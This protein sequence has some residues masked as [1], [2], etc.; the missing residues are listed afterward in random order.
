M[1]VCGTGVQCASSPE[2]LLA[3]RVPELQLH[4]HPRLH[5][6]K[7]HVEVHPHRLVGG[8]QERVFSVALEQGGLAHRGVAQHDDPELVLPHSRVHGYWRVKTRRD[9]H[10]EYKKKE[11]TQEKEENQQVHDWE[12]AASK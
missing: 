7:A 11:A 10:I 1:C 6:Q 5:V 9:K 8:V 3:R 12:K 4:S 2:P